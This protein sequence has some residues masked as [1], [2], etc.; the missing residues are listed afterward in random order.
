[1]KQAIKKTLC[2]VLTAF[3]LLTAAPLSGF[4][5][6]EWPD[7]GFPNKGTNVAIAYA[8]T[9]YKLSYNANGGSGTPSGQTGSTSYTISSVRPTR[10]G[11]T[12]RG[13]S[14]S[15][16]TST[17]SYEPG[18]PIS[19][20]SDTTLYAVW[21]KTFYGDVNNDGN[22]N[23][24]DTALLSN[25]LAQTATPNSL[26]ILKGDLNGDGALTQTDLLILSQ[27]CDGVKYSFP[28]EDMFG[29]A[30]ITM[31]KTDYKTGESIKVDSFNVLYTNYVEHKVTSGFSFTP[32]IA[33][34]SGQQIVSARLGE[35]GARMTITVD[36]SV[37]C[38]LTYNANGG[39][40][41]PSSQTGATSYTISST[42]PTRFGYTFCGW[43]KSSSSTTWNYSIG[44]EIT[45]TSDMTLYAVWSSAKSMSIGTSYAENISFANQERY[46]SFIPS[47]DGV[48]VF[49]S[50][51]SL[52][53]KVYIYTSSG[54]ELG[55]NDDGGENSNFRLSIN[56]TAG[57]KYYIKVRAYSNKTGSTSFDVRKES[58]SLTYNANGGSGAPS[59]QT[60]AT[61]YTIPKTE[62]G[63]S[64][65]TFRGWAKSSSAA[66]VA[67]RPGDTVNIT[68]STTLYA[69]WKKTFYGDVNNDGVVNDDDSDLL[70][71][72]VVKT[73]TPDSLNILK[74]DLNG[75]GVLSDTD[76]LILTQYCNKLID[77][78]PV[79]ELFG[80]VGIT[81]AKTTYLPG[82]SIKKSDITFNV[83]Y[84]NYV[85]HNVTTGFT[86]TPT[87]ASGTDKMQVTATLG[88]WQA[89]YFITIHTH[90]YSSKITKA[91]T[92]TENGIKTYTCAGC[93]DSYTESI[94]A[95]GHKWTAADC[96]SAKTCSV[97]KK[98]DGSPLGHNY[99]S[100]ITKV[101]T[102]TEKGIKTYT[103]SRCSHSYTEAIE[104]GPHKEVTIPAVEA[105]CAKTGLTAGKKCSVCNT[106]T[107]VQTTTE[108]KPHTWTAADCDS[109]KTCSVC[110]ASD[111]SALGHNYSS[112][113]TKAATCTEKGIKTYTCSRCSHSYTEAIEK[114]PHKEVTIPAV[115]AT[116]AK[117][118]LTAGKKCSV[119]NTITVAQTTTSKKAHTWTA[120]DCDSAKTCSV[121]KKTDGSP[122]GHNYSSKITKAATCTENGIKTYT[123]SRCSDSYTESIPA[124]G[125][126]WTAADCDSAKTCSVCKKTD[127]SPLGHNYSSKI[128]KAATCTEN[129][130]KT[131]TCS[132]CS[133]TYTENINP[134]SHVDNNNDQH[135]DYCNKSLVTEII[136][137]GT[138]GENL[139]WTLDKV[140][141][142]IISGTGVMTDYNSYSFAPWSSNRSAIKKAVIENGVTSIGGYV[143]YDCQ[144]L[145]SVTIPDSVTNIGEDAF[146]RCFSLISVTFGENSQLMSIGSSAFN[147]CFSLTSVTIPDSVTSIGDWA[148]GQC[149][150]LTSVTIPDSVTSIGDKAFYNCTSLTDITVDAD[151]TKYCSEDGVLF[152]KSKTELI[153]YPVGNART[154]YTI[155]DSVTSI[156]EYAFYRC[157]SLT[158]I[159]IPISMQLIAHTA[160]DRCDSLDSVFYEGTESDW[161]AIVIYPSGNENLLNATIFY[162][163][164]MKPLNAITY[165]GHY[166]KLFDKSFNWMDAESYC[167]K[168]NGHLVTV[169]D[170]YENEFI[171]DLLQQYAEK[172]CYWAGIYKDVRR[173]QWIHIDGSSVSF[174]N[175]A[176]NEPNNFNDNEMVV[177]L[178][179][180][181]YGNGKGYKNVGDWNDCSE[182]GASYVDS[183]YD[184]SNFGFICEWDNDQF[185]NGTVSIHDVIA[186]KQLII[187]TRNIDS[188]ASYSI[189]NAS[190]AEKKGDL[191]WKMANVTA[192]IGSTQFKQNNDKEIILKYDQVTDAVV[193]S[194]AD[195]YNYIIPKDV[196]LSLFEKGVKNL[197]STTAYMRK[198]IK[199]GKPYISTV[200]AK[201]TDSNTPYLELQCEELVVAK[202][203]EYSFYITADNLNESATYYISQDSSHWIESK[204]GAFSTA[205]IRKKLQNGKDTYVYCVTA[206]G[207]DSEEVKIKLKFED[208]EENVVIRELKEG[209]LNI[210]GEEGL[211]IT[212]PPDWI[213]IG[214]SSI[215]LCDWSF[216]IGLQMEGDTVR[217]SI[218]FDWTKTTT[219][220]TSYVSTDKKTKEDYSSTQIKIKNTW[221]NMKN[222]LKG[223][224]NSFKNAKDKAEAFKCKKN[225][226]ERYGIDVDDLGQSN[227]G[228]TNL[229][230]SA[231]G[232]LEA[233]LVNGKFIVTDMLLSIAG[234]FT[235]SYTVQLSAGYLGLEAGGKLTI[236]TNWNRLTADINMP[237]EFGVTVNATPWLKARGGVGWDGIASAG[238][239]GKGELPID[240]A[241]KE[242]QFSIAITG[243][244]GYEAQVLI[245]KTGEKVLLNGTFGPKVIYWGKSNVNRSFPVNTIADDGA[246]KEEYT[247]TDRVQSSAWWGNNNLTDSLHNRVGVAS[248]DELTFKTLQSDV[249]RLSD[250]KI[251]SAGE[252]TLAVWVAEDAARDDY[253]RLKLV[254]SV[255]DKV[256]DT[257]SEP[258]A[259]YD[260][261]FMDAS[262]ML[263]TDG[264]NVFVAWQKFCKTFTAD[265]GDDI[266]SVLAAA[267]IYT[268]KYDA[269]S[270]TFIDATRITNDSVYDY[271]PALTVVDGDAVVVYASNKN[272]D[273]LTVDG[274]SITKTRNGNKTVLAKNLSTVNN[275]ACVADENEIKVAYSVDTD[276]N[277]KT[278][279]DISVFSGTDSFEE[280][281][282]NASLT[283]FVYAD[284]NGE[285]TLFVSDGKNIYYSDNGEIKPILEEDVV[286]S[287]QLQ[288][289]NESEGLAFYWLA[290]SENGNELYTCSNIDGEW[291]NAICLSERENDFSNLAVTVSN[292]QVIGIANE[293]QISYDETTQ[294]Y[295]KGAT[296]FVFFKENDRF[297]LAMMFV[298]LDENNLTVGESAFLEVTAQNVGNVKAEN[299]T[300]TVTD[301][302]GTE[303]EYLVEEKLL[304]GKSIFWKIPYTIPAN[305][306]QTNVT[307]TVSADAYTD[308]DMTDNSASCGFET[309]ALIA[310]ANEVTEIEKTFIFSADITNNNFA[311]AKNVS[312][313]VS[314]NDPTGDV[315]S[316]VKIGDIA[317]DSLAV[318]EF[319]FTEKDLVFDENGVAVIYMIIKA[320][321]AEDT[322]CAFTVEQSTPAFT[323]GDVDANGKIEATDARLALRSAVKLETLTEAQTQAADADKDGEITSSDARLI[324]RAA[325]GLDTLK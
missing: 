118:G 25:F 233:T 154:S 131:Y 27:F 205:D 319:A 7:I 139:T 305:I 87:V 229:G 63:R 168:M 196:A 315:V 13:W 208:P 318:A 194:H 134:I 120:A 161:N 138:C 48:Y 4:V 292:G 247:L 296:N 311:I 181:N 23:S 97:C 59:S 70:G 84:T 115:E 294:T 65:Y 230:V 251:I 122:L 109:A 199:N 108:K 49:E 178:F 119:C 215:D 98:T 43:S 223:S 309:A 169:N 248:A 269:A 321:N 231:M 202:D 225:L 249:F 26:N 264:E 167:E 303:N 320:D 281:A 258:K 116:C 228:K 204:T 290:S 217:V 126:K 191:N 61:S 184:L 78:F 195:Y 128:T 323:L 51:G 190:I 207:V 289:V 302:N 35:W 209:K 255:Y 232:Y 172:N 177:H 50:N 235:L 41:A 197:F 121:C 19:L 279:N 100:K 187:S 73:L 299:L 158:S 72:Y 83:T 94:P 151:N 226:C 130:I 271:R 62:P 21:Q 273:V 77:K 270:D 300:F 267:E 1:M 265:S 203:K 224:A 227:V 316:T 66:T 127:G 2:I 88:D 312:A 143:F 272:N 245:W 241:F 145:T 132:R 148:F 185:Y 266:A 222:S 163:Y 58:F 192:K 140:G 6:L 180:K 5:G 256:F 189:G 136:Q 188:W 237:L 91:A 238:V 28:V 274:N 263:A 113:I 79:E 221:I 82:E 42:V 254:Y 175:W 234:E 239:Y 12:F 288:A 149:T 308:A 242:K 14:S 246:A 96:D 32:T 30:S 153:Q 240:V 68:S 282:E 166:Y 102:C 110:G 81:L 157:T 133:D 144:K 186:D 86:Y 259:V 76:M 137:S 92:C 31:K 306:A 155:P 54:T 324:L 24:S 297:D 284:Y 29:L 182:D 291:T 220:N 176:S 15:S 219:T 129:G 57:T 262:P 295:T 213:M 123:C 53:T 40:G 39:S 253:N 218:G 52:D 304:P 107:V 165:N 56:L 135:C 244:F 69:V 142:L 11:Y 314:F 146:A 293:T 298:D 173:D 260:D 67:Y 268:A 18:D 214:G 125:H 47:S 287:T 193:L 162:E 80:L 150:S 206:S 201:A 210:G 170:K 171:I 317:K 257:W 183:F 95:A 104:K 101:A 8:A 236:A 174:A 322:I 38:T 55:N 198:E 45:L 34:G 276:G 74:G 60:G 285:K 124:A 105:T 141:T 22:V 152:N 286:I 44:D 33:S 20:S 160:F 307:V 261:G 313:A 310:E 90:S 164:Y 278:T 114:V 283:N 75:D 325:V 36:D 250:A 89:Y 156:G 277:L 16:N 147:S 3:M 93:S 252:T 212:L 10:S 71:K 243:E 111:G 9:S 46:Y 200:F 211:K 103:C 99:S 216:P 275:L 159:A 37:G 85:Q 117:T 301:S 280:F 179:G 64:G 106:I 112:K 17:A